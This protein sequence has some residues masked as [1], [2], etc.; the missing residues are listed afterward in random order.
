MVND[1]AGNHEAGIESASGDAAQG[2]PCPVIKPVP[3][4]VES[5]CDQVFCRSEVEP[6]IDC[7][8]VSNAIS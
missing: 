3:K 8:G 6:R 5:I 1:T 2:M 4:F 7:M